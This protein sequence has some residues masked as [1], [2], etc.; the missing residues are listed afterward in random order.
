M[1]VCW[2]HITELWPVHTYRASMLMGDRV[3][4]F[5]SW[6]VP[7]GLSALRLTFSLGSM[8]SVVSET[9]RFVFGLQSDVRTCALPFG[10]QT[11]ADESHD[12]LDFIH[13]ARWN[14]V[15]FDDSQRLQPQRGSGQGLDRNTA[16]A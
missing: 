8:T 6:W 3:Q 2:C 16:L 9:F 10:G 7:S 14:E 11:N 4:S 5:G 1:E 13:R 12:L 15:P